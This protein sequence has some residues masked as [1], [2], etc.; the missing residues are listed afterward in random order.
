MCLYELYT[1]Q[2]MFPGFNNSD[3][4]HRM[5]LCKGA[6][7]KKVIKAHIRAC[8][9]TR[10]GDAPN[11]YFHEKSFHFIYRLSDGSHLSPMIIPREPAKDRTIHAMLQA[12]MPSHSDEGEMKLVERLADILERCL[13]MN[14]NWRFGAVDAL[15]H[16]FFN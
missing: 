4:L 8:K 2:V 13:N 10:D 3:M 9:K 7:H 15:R 16:D 14:R 1:G 11:L 12:S 6:L 5:L